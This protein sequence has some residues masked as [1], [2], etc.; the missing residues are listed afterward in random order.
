[1]KGKLFLAAMLLLLVSCRTK[2]LA[3]EVEVLKTVQSLKI[4]YVDTT[5]I[6]PATTFEAVLPLDTV[7]ITID[8]DD[9]YVQAVYLPERNAVKLRVYQKPKPL[10]FTVTELEE[11]TT[12][13]DST[14]RTRQTGPI[15]QAKPS[16]WRNGY[17][18]AFWGFFG[19]ILFIAVWAYRQVKA[20][21]R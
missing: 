10:R 12:T 19:L 1:M 5:V 15:V 21:K 9:R 8:D 20:N 6:V 2:R 7:P 4:E 18:W 14:G 13:L 16:V 17:F 3:Q 11:I